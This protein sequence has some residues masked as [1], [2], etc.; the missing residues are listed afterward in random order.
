MD[1]SSECVFQ[2]NTEIPIIIDRCDSFISTI[3]YYYI[4][5]NSEF[6]TTG[7]YRIFVTLTN[8]FTENITCAILKFCSSTSNRNAIIGIII[9]FIVIYNK[10]IDYFLK[11]EQKNV[12]ALL[13][14]NY[15]KTFWDLE[16]VLSV[17]SRKNN[18]EKYDE[19]YQQIITMEEKL[20]K[21]KNLKFESELDNSGRT[22]IS[23][24]SSNL[25]PKRPTG[26][27]SLQP[28]SYSWRTNRIRGGKSRSNKKR[29]NKNKQNTKTRMRKGK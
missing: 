18:T 6:Q 14:S 25:T 1:K 28:N 29:L 3:T 21:L 24:N 9:K 23:S 26:N 5:P 4:N 10:G 15:N 13:F 20:N 27:R 22:T 11:N 16:M 19:L 8:F 17:I 12:F 2:N 7:D